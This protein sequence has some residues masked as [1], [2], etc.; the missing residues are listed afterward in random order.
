MK[1]NTTVKEPWDLQEDKKKM[2]DEEFEEFDAVISIILVFF[3]I[4]FLLFVCWIW[5]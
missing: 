4:I 3:I 5:F 2:S 1:K